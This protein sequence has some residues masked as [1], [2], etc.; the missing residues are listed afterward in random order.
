[1]ESD[2]SR[3]RSAYCEAPSAATDEGDDLELVAVADESGSELRPAEDAAIHLDGDAGRVE[4]EILEELPDRG[5]HGKLTRLTIEP[6]ADGVSGG[7]F[8]SS[9]LFAAR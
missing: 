6:D 4:P 2:L 3:S 8:F 1:M 7:Y 5:P 9:F